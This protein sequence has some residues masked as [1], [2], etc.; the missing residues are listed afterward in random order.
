[1]ESRELPEGLGCEDT[2]GSRSQKAL[3]DRDRSRGGGRVPRDPGGSSRQEKGL[4][5]K[6]GSGKGGSPIM[7]RACTG[8]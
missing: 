5:R 8:T 7:Q 1:M 4:S 2:L 3:L 6:V